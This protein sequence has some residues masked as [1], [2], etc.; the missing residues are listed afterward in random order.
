MRLRPFFLASLVLACTDPSVPTATPGIAP[1]SDVASVTTTPALDHRGRSARSVRIDLALGHPLPADA[2]RAGH[3]VIVGGGASDGELAAIARRRETA[4]LRDREVPLFAWGDPENA[5]TTIHVQPS[6]PLD[7]GRAT[8]ILLVDRHEPFVFDMTARD[9]PDPARRVWPLDD[10]GAGPTESWTWCLRDGW[11]DDFPTAIDLAPQAIQ[12]AVV[13]RS[14]SPCIDV[15]PMTTPSAGTIV[16]PPTIGATAI[17]PS[18]ITIAAASTTPPPD[19]S[20]RDGELALGPL[21]ARVDDDRLVF[22]GASAPTL[23]LGDVGPANVF[24]ALDASGRLVVR[25]LAPSSTIDL[26]LVVRTSAMESSFALRATLARPHRHVVVNEAL[27]HP[28]SGAPTQRF[29]ELVNDGDR[30]ANVGGLRLQ[31]GETS[32]D[33]PPRALPPGAFL[34]V[35]PT[36]WIDGLGGDVPAPAGVARVSIDS[37][38]ASGAITLFDETGA[39][40]SSFPGSASTRT[41]SR[42]RRDPDAPDDAPDAFGFDVNGRA[43]PGAPNE[44]E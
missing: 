25:G 18:P 7:A 38:P 33:L 28:P 17:D 12:A 32:I 3:V 34:L 2:T 26:A 11:P 24:A 27:A 30:S 22:L 35:L 9:E 44:I 39:I 14:D 36:D 23:L 4:A 13:R 31:W 42:G 43:T 19:A 6:R 40:L 20:C 29:V 21:C 15:T 16:A 10:A 8:L 5:P 1:P 41:A 37:L